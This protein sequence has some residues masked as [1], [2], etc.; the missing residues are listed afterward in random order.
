MRDTW[1]VILIRKGELMARRRSSLF[2][3]LHNDE[4]RRSARVRPAAD[5][6]QGSLWCVSAYPPHGPRSSMPFVDESESLAA[7]AAAAAIVGNLPFDLTEE[8]LVEVSR[9]FC[10]SYTC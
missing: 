7:A 4:L 8:Q 3:L 5:A 9:A 6:V 2:T 10:P 1:I